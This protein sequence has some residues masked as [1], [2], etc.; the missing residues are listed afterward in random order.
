MLFDKRTKEVIFRNMEELGGEMSQQDVMDII[1]PYM[2]ADIDIAKLKEQYC[3]RVANGLMSRYRDERGIRTCFTVKGG[4]GS[5]YVNIDKTQSEE[6]LRSINTA[7]RKKI[8][9]LISSKNKVS[10]N[11][12]V[13]AGQMTI[14]DVESN[15]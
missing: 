1:R 8:N 3:R 7:L 14:E 11:M 2:E 9:G 5:K 15:G 4:E 10:K 12:R 6:D 13:L